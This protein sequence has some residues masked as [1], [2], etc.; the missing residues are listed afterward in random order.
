[1]IGAVAG[2]LRLIPRLGQEHSQKGEIIIY[3]KP[4]HRAIAA[5]QLVAQATIDAPE[6]F[7]LPNLQLGLIG[8]DIAVH[9]R[10]Y[11]VI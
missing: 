11:P 5:L 2:P 8:A 4:S 10:L 9:Q 6:A 7:I 3:Q 1:M